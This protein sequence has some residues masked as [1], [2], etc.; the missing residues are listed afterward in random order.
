MKK[1]RI[2]LIDDEASFTRLLRLN[3]EQTGRYEVRDLNVA[4]HAIPVIESFD[5]DLILLDI[6]MPNM[7][8][9]H[10]AAEILKR[11]RVKNTPIVFLTAVVSKQETVEQHGLIGG[12]LFLAKP[13][14]LNEVMSC[15]D[16]ILQHGGDPVAEAVGPGAK[17][18]G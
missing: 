18:R 4:A 7:D 12:N 10:L 5:P 15:I 13:V 8:G 3:L 6:V 2:L 1:P 14:T 17:R 11:P 9:A 16:K